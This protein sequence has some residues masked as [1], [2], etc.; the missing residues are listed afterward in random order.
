MCCA[1]DSQ[2]SKQLSLKVKETN[3]DEAM[4]TNPDHVLSLP[5]PSIDL[6]VP[7]RVSVYATHLHL[8]AFHFM[9][10]ERLTEVMKEM[11]T[12]SIGVKRI[13]D[14]RKKKQSA[15]AGVQQVLADMLIYGSPGWGKVGTY[16]HTLTHIQQPYT[17]IHR[18]LP[19]SADCACCCCFTA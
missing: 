8:R 14:V 13:G 19:R 17:A 5:Y 9:G 1:D 12:L 16:H 11:D 18:S 6:R 4:L 7:E 2:R 3:L 10:R 15:A